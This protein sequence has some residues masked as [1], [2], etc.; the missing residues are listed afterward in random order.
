MLKM[1]EEG[2]LTHFDLN[3]DIKKKEF[4]DIEKVICFR[5]LCIV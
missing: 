4:I 5:G 2:N 3:E 1:K